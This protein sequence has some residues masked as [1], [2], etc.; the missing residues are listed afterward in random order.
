[1]A[2]ANATGFHVELANA[3]EKLRCFY[4]DDADTVLRVIELAG[5]CLKEDLA[6]RSVEALFA[7]DPPVSGITLGKCSEAEGISLRMLAQ[8]WMAAL[9]SLYSSTNEQDLPQPLMLAEEDTEGQRVGD[10]LP[11]LVCDFVK[12]QREGFGQYFSADLRE[13]RARRAKG[14]S[15][16]VVIDYAGPKLVANF[17]TLKAGAITNSVHLIKRRLWDLKVERD[18]EPHNALSRAHEMILHRPPKDD[19]QVSEQQQANIGDA[20]EDL[21]QQ[22][23]QEELRLLA[24]DTVQAIG[25]RVLHY[26]LA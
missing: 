26:E 1:M 5:V 13:G 25:Q 8:S 10:R 15:H 22:A 20:L 4:G 24:L 23:D 21:E 6:A 2:A 11:F 16:R 17:G 14:G 12:S 9:S 3:P 7:P 18:R 19:P